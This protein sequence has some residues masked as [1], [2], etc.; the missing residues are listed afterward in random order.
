MIVKCTD[1]YK[2]K[3]LEVLKW[4]FVFVGLGDILGKFIVFAEH[5]DS[6]KIGQTYETNF[7]KVDL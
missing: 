6:Y 5:E 2:N 4:A 3:Q 1:K 7:E